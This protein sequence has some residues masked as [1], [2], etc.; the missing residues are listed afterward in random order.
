MSVAYYMQLFP[1]R[2]LA[3]DVDRL[4]GVPS[5]LPSDGYPLSAEFGTQLRFLAQFLP[6][7][8]WSLP[9]GHTLQIYQSQNI[10]DGDDPLPVA[11]LVPDFATP[12]DRMIGRDVAYAPRRIEWKQRDDPAELPTE[13]ALL[14]RVVGSKIG[15]TPV[16]SR[17]PKEQ[18]E[19]VLQLNEE[20]DL[21]FGGLILLVWFLPDGEVCC[22]LV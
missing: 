10:D 8:R 17:A 15:G 14:E 6:S 3:C 18:A 4:G 16:S 21:N 2:D 22:E 1:C 7:D 12:N 13:M 11:K 9:A 19:Y 20:E 5:R